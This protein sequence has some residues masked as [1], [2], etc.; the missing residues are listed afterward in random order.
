[1]LIV[2]NNL[3]G[4][5]QDQKKLDEAEKIFREVLGMSSLHIS[6]YIH[7]LVVTSV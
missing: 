6:L 4:I 1:M 2:L 5:L 7:F 3:A